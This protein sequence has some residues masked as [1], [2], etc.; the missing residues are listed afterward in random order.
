MAVG[1]DPFQ[2]VPDRT[3]SHLAPRAVAMPRPFNAAAICR[4]DFAPAPWARPQLSSF[5]TGKSFAAL[6]SDEI[7]ILIGPNLYDLTGNLLD[8]LAVNGGPLI[9]ALKYF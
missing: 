1:R 3:A 5:E 8:R 4:S 2:H 7:A 6:K 9:P